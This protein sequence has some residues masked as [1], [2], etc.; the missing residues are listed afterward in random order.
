MRT[1]IRH[2]VLL[3]VFAISLT[4]LAVAQQFAYRVAANIP[5]D[6]YIGDQQYLAGNYLFAVNYGDHAVTIT[7]QT[8]GHSSV[9]FASPLEPASP[10]YDSRDKATFVELVPVGDRY[11]L[12]DVQTRTNGVSFP[13][14]SLPRTAATNEGIVTIVAS[15]R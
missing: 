14:G 9:V 4:E 1:H 5:Y 15:L 12:S 10:G 3:A 7:N 11:L 2:L 6:F 8:S 13:K